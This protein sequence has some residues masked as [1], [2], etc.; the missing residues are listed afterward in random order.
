MESFAPSV[1]VPER[2]INGWTAPA[3][4]FT[5]EGWEWILAFAL[6]GCG[7]AVEEA[8]KPEFRR[9]VIESLKERRRE[10][11]LM[12]VEAKLDE[13]EQLRRELRGLSEGG[14]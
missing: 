12:A 3:Y 4:D 10:S 7:W 11:L 8:S 5:P 9:R 14:P 13:I 1:H 2:R 6:R